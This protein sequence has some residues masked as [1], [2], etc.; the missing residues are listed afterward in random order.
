MARELDKQK[1]IEIGKKLAKA[2]FVKTYK[3]K[4]HS[5]D[6]FLLFPQTDAQYR[7]LKKECGTTYN[8]VI[9]HTAAEVLKE[10]PELQDYITPT[11]SGRFCRINI[12]L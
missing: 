4:S 1:V 6:V 2:N 12:S 8:L 5:H 11:K 9:I 3:P 7:W 10:I